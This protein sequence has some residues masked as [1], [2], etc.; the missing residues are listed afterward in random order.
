M[1]Q[2]MAL[3]ALALLILV[4]LNCGSTEDPTDKI[5]G[6]QLESGNLQ[7]QVD[8]IE[9][10]TI[11]V[12]LLKDGQLI[13]QTDSAANYELDEL[14]QG[15]YTVEISAKGFETTEI[16]VNIVAGET[17]VLDKVTL[18][19]LE[20]P[21]A[22][23]S[24]KLTDDKT[25]NVLSD[26][27]VKL[28]YKSGEE[29]KTLTSDDGIFTFEN[30]PVNQ[31]FTVSVMLTGYEDFD[32]SVD[33]IDAGKTHEI[34]VKLTPIPDPEPLGPGEGLHTGSKAPAFELPDSNDQIRSLA[35]FV[36]NKRAVI[37][38]YRGGW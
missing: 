33:S 30:L 2:T 26:V 9:G 3:M 23:L 18:S 14:E 38:F 11:H 15:E 37:V 6:T 13:G 36:D 10:V 1:K 8:E 21:V 34:D 12:R 20:D 35:E 27:L 16:K 32:L 31:T 4:G 5:D 7:V 25:G 22:H 29:Y 24:G 28:T 19:P 17:N